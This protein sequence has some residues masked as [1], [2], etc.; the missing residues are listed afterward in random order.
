MK[1]TVL[2][3]LSLSIFS[4]F[5]CAAKEVRLGPETTFPVSLSNKDIGVWIA[6]LPGDG[7][8]EVRLRLLLQNR[9]EN[10]IS[11]EP[12][13]VVLVDGSGKPKEQSNSVADVLHH[14]REFV[15]QFRVSENA[16]KVKS[17][18]VKPQD[19]VELYHSFNLNNAILGISRHS[20]R[21]TAKVRYQIA[22]D[23]AGKEMVWEAQ[24]EI[25]R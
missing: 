4:T 11:I 23:A 19:L 13:K 15:S 5:G 3:L 20:Q 17:L 25:L 8:G 2:F 18:E 22:K 12:G 10:E 14:K 1:I 9:G 6:C 21:E 16:S 7:P 24:C